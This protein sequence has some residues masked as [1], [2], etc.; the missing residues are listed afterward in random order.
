MKTPV[1]IDLVWTLFY[2]PELTAPGRP[3]YRNISTVLT[4][5]SRYMVTAVCAALLFGFHILSYMYCVNYACFRVF[6]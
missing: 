4:G 3:Q 2:S 1:V 6:L 5:A